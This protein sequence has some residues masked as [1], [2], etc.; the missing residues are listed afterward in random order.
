M[1]FMLIHVLWLL[2][3]AWVDKGKGRLLGNGLYIYSSEIH[4]FKEIIE[5]HVLL[6]GTYFSF[7]VIDTKYNLQV[8]T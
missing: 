5:K 1:W 6:Y 3:N 7:E 4:Y 8:P 2:Y